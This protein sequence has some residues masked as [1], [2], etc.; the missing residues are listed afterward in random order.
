MKRFALILTVIATLAGNSAF[1]QTG[2]G[3]AAGSN[4]AS[5]FSWGIAIGGLA[6]LGVVVG[7]TA[8]AASSSPSTFSH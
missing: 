6:V 2:R 1:A 8:A 4:G 3:A 7:I 5:G